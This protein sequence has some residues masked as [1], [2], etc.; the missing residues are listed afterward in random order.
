MKELDEGKFNFITYTIQQI[1]GDLEYCEYAGIDPG[2]L[3]Y[4]WAC[5][6]DEVRFRLTVSQETIQ[7]IPS[8]QL[9][10]HLLSNKLKDKVVEAINN[11]PPKNVVIRSTEI[12]VD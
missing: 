7:D 1:V 3:A 2:S 9:Y 4:A 12:V 11:D 6:F 10:D 5:K 8:S